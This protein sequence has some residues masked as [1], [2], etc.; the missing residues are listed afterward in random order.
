MCISYGREGEQDC[1][2]QICPLSCGEVL[3]LCVAND[4]SGNAGA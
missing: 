4:V 3:L 1:L 2:I